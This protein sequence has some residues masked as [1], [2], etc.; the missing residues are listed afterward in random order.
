MA[1]GIGKEQIDGLAR[2]RAVGEAE[3]GVL[4]RLHPLAIGRGV[5]HPAR[6]DFRM[7]RHARAVVVFGLVVNRHTAPRTATP[8][9]TLEDRAGRRKQ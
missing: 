9:A 3:L 1:G 6:E 5:A 2:A 4:V 7:L 8:E